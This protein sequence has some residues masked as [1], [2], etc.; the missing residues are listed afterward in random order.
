[1]LNR[2]KLK[3]VV[4]MCLLVTNTVTVFA[5]ATDEGPE[6]PPPSTPINDWIPYVVVAVVFLVLVKF[7]AQTRKT[8]LDS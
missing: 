3:L 5:Q 8:R 4:L 1:M 6:P 2:S 7:Y